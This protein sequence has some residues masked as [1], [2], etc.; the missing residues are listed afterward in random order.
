MP[1]QDVQLLPSVFLRGAGLAGPTLS[2]S[3]PRG[4]DYSP[5]GGGWPF[6]AVF[7]LSWQFILFC[8]VQLLRFCF[9]LRSLP[10]GVGGLVLVRGVVVPVHTGLELTVLLSG[11]LCVSIAVSYTAVCVD[12]HFSE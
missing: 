3:L 4:V 6:L 5:R 1:P 8:I 12:F 7:C 10:V 9:I 2:G 11:K